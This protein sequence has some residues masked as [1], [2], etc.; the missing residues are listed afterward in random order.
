MTAPTSEHDCSIEADFVLRFERVC[1][2]IGLA[3][4]STQRRLLAAHRK[5]MLA[6]QSAA[7]ATE[8]LVY[9]KGLRRAELQPPAEGP[10]DT[11]GQDEGR[12]H[13]AAE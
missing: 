7:R 5:L 4:T 1:D 3:L 8:N 13:E 9:L 10:Q 11:H 6:E 2:L 12:A